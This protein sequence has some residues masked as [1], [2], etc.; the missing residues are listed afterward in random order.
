MPKYKM[1]RLPRGFGGVVLMSGKRAK[2]Y[3]VRVKVG[4]I[5]NEYKGTAYP[6][7]K[8]IGYASSR[9]DG[10]LMLQ[11]YHE[12]PYDMQNNYTFAEIYKKA[13]DEFIADKS[14]S[15]ILSY[16]ACY[17]TCKDLHGLIFK[18]IKTVHLQKVIDTCGK[19]Y[20]TLRKIKVL[21]NTMYKYAMKYDLC[22]KD[23][24]KYVDIV[25]HNKVN[26][27]S[28][29]RN[30]FTKK[31]I[32]TLWSM[33][34]N[35]WFQIPL[36]LI[37]T[38]VRIGELLELNKEDVNLDE[39]YFDIN[40]SKTENGI[41]RVPIADCIFPFFKHWME[42]SKAETLLCTPNMEP[43]KYRNY[44]DAYWTP[45]LDQVNLGEYTPH[46]TRHT[47][48]SLLAEAKVD[49]TTIKKIVGHRGAMTL[50]E[51]VYTHFDVQ[52]LIDAVNKM[53]VPSSK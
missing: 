39:R 29:D 5:I 14:K 38:G 9:K 8:I 33:Q 4:M 22:G 31:A 50:T 16:E 21:F 42:Y 3:M 49:Q 2:P 24:S 36:M 43:F 18:E 19:N 11:Q 46:C 41:R 23:Y 13:F 47:C 34:D 12:N 32:D 48:I 30:P 53:Y 10:I 27:N 1:E 20:P 35:Q 26:P 15:S 44:Y 17:K 6:K 51:K 28:R 40:K 45:T 7:Y 52:V 37:Y 25:K